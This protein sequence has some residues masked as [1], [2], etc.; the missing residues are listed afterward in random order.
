MN[1]L[2]VCSPKVCQ[3]LVTAMVRILP[4]SNVSAQGTAVLLIAGSWPP[5]SE[6]DQCDSQHQHEASCPD[7]VKHIPSTP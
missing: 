5:A 7:E 3:R 6:L 2:S 1:S 4:K